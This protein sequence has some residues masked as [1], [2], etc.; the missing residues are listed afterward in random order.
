MTMKQKICFILL[1]CLSFKAF[2][3]DGGIKVYSTKCLTKISSDSLSLDIKITIANNSTVNYYYPKAFEQQ[4]NGH[5]LYRSFRFVRFLHPV[6]NITL[7]VSSMGY[8]SYDSVLVIKP[9]DT[10][11]L[12]YENILVSV[13][14]LEVVL[15][16]YVFSTRNAIKATSAG[17]KYLDRYESG[18]KIIQYRLDY[19]KEKVKDS[20]VIRSY[21]NLPNKNSNP[22]SQ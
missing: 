20:V 6:E 13:K 5:N 9:S 2:A 18:V 15:D 14:K 19:K 21:L 4:L 7:D 22:G 8:N 10:L 17:V 16:N 3:Q 1:C 11:V 12:I